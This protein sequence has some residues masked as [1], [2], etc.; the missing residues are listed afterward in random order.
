MRYS[1]P[2]DIERV[3]AR[4]LRF[5]MN[6]DNHVVYAQITCE[7]VL[8]KPDSA[9]IDTPEDLDHAKR[10]LARDAHWTFASEVA[11]RNRREQGGVGYDALSPIFL[12]YDNIYNSK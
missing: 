11:E 6:V 1:K 8:R 12:S 3:T 7:A 10:L 9:K 2:Y 4:L 5:K